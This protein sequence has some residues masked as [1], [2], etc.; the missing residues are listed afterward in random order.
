MSSHTI[1]T[2]P[3]SELRYIIQW[4]SEWSDFQREDFLPILVEYL[5]RT[6]SSNQTVYLNGIVNSMASSSCLDKPMSLFQCRV[7]QLL[8]Y[9]NQCL[10]IRVYFQIKLFKEWSP[11]WSPD[12]RSRLV[13]KINELDSDFGL[14][15][16]QELEEVLKIEPPMQN[17]NSIPLI[18]EALE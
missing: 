2:N 6:S 10:I 7:R 9:R 5:I 12:L 15:L 16:N 3:E 8:I 17:G 14:K 11:N 13:D 4:F 1:Q 18:V